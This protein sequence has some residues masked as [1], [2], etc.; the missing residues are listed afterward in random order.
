MHRAICCALL[1]S[2]ALA[3]GDVTG[4]WKGRYLVTRTDGTTAEAPACLILEQN[5]AEV[6]GSGG[7]NEDKQKAFDR[8]RID[9]DRVVLEQDH[10]SGRTLILTLTMDGDRM[11]G[12]MN[13]GGEEQR[14][15]AR[16]E[17]ERQ[18]P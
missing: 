9:G 8:A 6:S 13:H 14:P 5:G 18:K 7:P 2:L 4:T 1:F 16:V 17:L 11:K 15:A 12:E 3:A 10:K